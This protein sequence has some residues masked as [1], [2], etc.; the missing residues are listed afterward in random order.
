MSAMDVDSVFTFAFL[1]FVAWLL[2]VGLLVL[3]LR[4]RHPD[5]LEVLGSPSFASLAPQHLIEGAKI[6]F[7][8]KHKTLNDPLLSAT[9]YAMRVV[10]LICMCTFAL[11][12]ALA[13]G[14]FGRAPPKR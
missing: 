3:R 2:L 4:S 13:L 1:P 14:E 6:M 8:A 11:V 7:S 5:A 10:A 12:F 9:V